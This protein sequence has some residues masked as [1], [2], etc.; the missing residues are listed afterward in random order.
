MSITRFRNSLSRYMKPLLIFIAGGFFIS[1]FT[2]YGNYLT[3]EQQQGKARDYI[4]K[5]NGKGIPTQLYTDRIALWEANIKNVVQREPTASDV[6]GQR[7]RLLDE[8]IDQT[9]REQAAEK[10]GI[11]VGRREVNEEIDRAVNARIDSERAQVVAR[12]AGKKKLSRRAQ[13]RKLEEILRIIKG[14]PELTIASYG[15][16]LRAELKGRKDE[17]RTSILIAKLDEAVRREIHMSEKELVDSYR[18]VRARHIL[19]SSSLRPE[20]RAKERAAE[21]L[22]ELRSGGDFAALARNN[23]DD[24]F[25]KKDGGLWP[26]AIS[27]EQ[28]YGLDPA[29]VRAISALRPG[30]VSNVVRTGEGYEIV[31]VESEERTLPPDFSANKKRYLAEAR[32]NKQNRVAA[33]YYAKLRADARI[34]VT[35]PSLRG[36]WLLAQVGI[37]M[38]RKGLQ[39]R[40]DALKK[41]ARAFET[42]LEETGDDSAAVFALAQTYRTLGET[43]KA[44]R[45]LEEGLDIPEGLTVEGPDLRIMLGD[46]YAEKKDIKRAAKQY[47][48]ASDVGYPD[49]TVHDRL[50]QS[51]KAI[52]RPDLAEK[53]QKLS[54]ELGPQDTG[55]PTY[56]GGAPVSSPGP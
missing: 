18:Q 4:A 36:Y 50:V 23:S 28:S 44:V 46:L 31:K 21:V 37:E 6:A 47:E 2:F 39:G 32:K 5:V 33:E 12:Y 13:D 53:E 48:L 56:P 1:I 15:K 20:A 7:M 14:N 52:G 42:G 55:Q 25:T 30:Q 49:Y 27:T 9:L 3:G 26:M 10:R 16:E 19:I 17:I 51:F 8:L 22:K 40:N 45:I 35:E 34:T 41:A 43:D 29:A 11:R 54:K 38:Q 24:T